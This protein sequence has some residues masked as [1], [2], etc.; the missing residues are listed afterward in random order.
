MPELTN[1]DRKNGLEFATRLTLLASEAPDVFLEKLVHR[2]A[3]TIRQR[4]G[5][6]PRLKKQEITRL[7]RVTNGG[8]GVSITELVDLTG[9][10]RP[11]MRMLSAR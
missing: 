5:Y 10:A 7:A 8:G 3:Q 9:W 11:E 4:Y 6:S 1:E 2:A